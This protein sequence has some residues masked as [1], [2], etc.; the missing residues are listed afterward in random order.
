MIFHNYSKETERE[1]CERTKKKA[2]TKKKAL[3]E[4]YIV[5]IVLSKSN[6]SDH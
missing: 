4:M 5:K 1:D 3:G 2:S 6:D